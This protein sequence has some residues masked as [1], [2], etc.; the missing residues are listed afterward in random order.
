MALDPTPRIAMGRV[1]IY[2]EHGSAVATVAM[3]DMDAALEAATLFAAAPQLL[4]ALEAIIAW[5]HS[6]DG[7]FAWEV[8]YQ[9]K[10]AI[11]AAQGEQSA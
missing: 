3:P 10:D 8:L 2:D 9:A 5:Q 7:P 1:V 6:E 4:A 11:A